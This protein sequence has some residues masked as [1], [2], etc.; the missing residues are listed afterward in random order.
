MKKRVTSQSLTYIEWVKAGDFAC[1]ACSPPTARAVVDFEGCA[2]FPRPITRALIGIDSAICEIYHVLFQGEACS[3]TTTVVRPAVGRDVTILTMP[4]REKTHA[5]TFWSRKTFSHRG[6][7]NGSDR[8]HAVE[9]GVV[10]SGC[11]RRCH[12]I[13]GGDM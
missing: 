6:R 1:A 10:C 12:L 2:L 11:S 9:D 3:Q 5:T 8:W 4:D 13:D 7:K